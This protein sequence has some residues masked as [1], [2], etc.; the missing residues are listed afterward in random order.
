MVLQ[1]EIIQVLL[2]AKEKGTGDTT[3]QKGTGET[4]PHPQKGMCDILPP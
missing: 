1:A 2:V 3:A 4:T